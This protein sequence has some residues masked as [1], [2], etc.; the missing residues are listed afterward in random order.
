LHSAFAVDIIGGAAQLLSLGAIATMRYLFSIVLGV[1]LLIACG[2][3]R[4]LKGTA[5]KLRAG[6]SQKEV[7]A[8]FASFN[9]GKTNEYHDP[10]E[11]S[12]GL[13]GTSGRVVFKT[14]VEHGTSIGYSPNGFV[15]FEICMVYFDTNGIIVGYNYHRE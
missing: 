9:Y 2:C 8:L 4:S 7:A 14:G 11:S 13:L 6:M 1:M 5:D 10:I 15:S 3:G 12:S